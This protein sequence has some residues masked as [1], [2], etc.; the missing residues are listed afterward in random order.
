M[1][2]KNDIDL[3]E[4]TYEK[5]IKQAH[6][7]MGKGGLGKYMLISESIEGSDKDRK[8][9]IRKSLSSSLR[10]FKAPTIA[11]EDEM[12]DRV[13][14]YF[15]T[16]YKFGDNPTVEGLTLALGVSDVTLLRWERGEQG[17]RRSHVV[18]KAKKIIQAYDADLL[19]KGKINVAGYIFRAK[20]YYGMV[21]KVEHAVTTSSPLD[22]IKSL[23]DISSRIPDSF[24]DADYVDLDEVEVE[25]GKFFEVER[26][27]K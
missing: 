25:E 10:F 14:E 13:L 1:S 15:A 17:E 11:T 3:S 6:K 21:D 7:D 19:A 9:E 2:K 16:C 8:E 12:E 27:E 4:E 20:N 22:D 24:I 5:A 26:K 18:K 23:E